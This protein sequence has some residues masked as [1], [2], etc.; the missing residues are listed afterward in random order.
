MY[1]ELLNAQLFVSMGDRRREKEE[2]DVHIYILFVCCCAATKPGSQRHQ[3]DRVADPLA[4]SR[5][6]GQPCLRNR[7]QTSAQWNRQL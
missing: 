2:T 1:T 4:Q 5:P 7:R 3:G 6:P